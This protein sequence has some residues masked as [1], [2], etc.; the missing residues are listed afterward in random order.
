MKTERSLTSYKFWNR[1]DGY[2][3]NNIAK[4][5]HPSTSVMF[6]SSMTVLFNIKLIYPPFWVSFILFLIVIITTVE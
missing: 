1:A 6:R 5:E 3:S 4:S 2:F